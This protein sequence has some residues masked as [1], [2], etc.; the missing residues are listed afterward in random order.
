MAERSEESAQSKVPVTVK[1]P[2]DVSQVIETGPEGGGQG[3]GQQ[4]KHLRTDSPLTPDITRA[5]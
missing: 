4:E 1:A 2:E 3:I 5:C